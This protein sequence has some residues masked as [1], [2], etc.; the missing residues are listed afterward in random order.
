ML[1][2]GR[3]DAH[4]PVAVFDAFQQVRR[5]E[6]LDAVGWW[7]AQRLEQPGRDQRRDVMRPAVQ[8]PGRLLRREAGWQL[9]QQHQ[10]PLLIVFHLNYVCIRPVFWVNSP[11]HL[12]IG[13]LQAIPSGPPPTRRSAPGGW[14]A[15]PG[16]INGLN[17]RNTSAF[18]R[19]NN[20]GFSAALT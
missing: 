9:A 4:Q 14:P 19:S 20:C 3:A 6:K 2:D 12:G 13:I 10:E 5:G 11:L 8:H 1:V 15:L 7:I 18:Y 17:R 16:P